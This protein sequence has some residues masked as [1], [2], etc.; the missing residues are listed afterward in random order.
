MSETLVWID[1]VIITCTLLISS[2]IGLYYRFSGGRQKTTEEFFVANRDMGVTTIAIGLMVSLLSAVSLLG[3]SSEIYMHGTHYVVI[4]L[5]YALATPVIAYFYLPVFFNLGDTSAFQYL[6][7][8]FGVKTR[9]VA[10][11]IFLVQF[12]L[13]SGVVLYAPAL[14]LEATTGLSTTISVIIIGAVCTFYSTIGGMKAVLITDV[15]QGILMIASVVI[16]IVTAVL[17]VGGINKIWDIAVEGKRIDFNSTSFDPTVRH[18]WWNLI[19][20][21]FFIYLSLYGVNQIQVQ[22]VLTIR[23]LKRAKA[24]VW[25]SLPITVI[26]VCGI[27]FSGLAL[28]SKYRNCDPRTAGA[29]ASNDQ[30]MPHYIMENLSKYPGIPGLFI[31]GIFS[32]GLSTVSAVQNSAAAIILE[33]YVKPVFQA[34]Q[35]TFTEDQSAYTSKFLAFLMGLVCLA[36]ALL[37]QQLG[38]LLQAALTIFGV[39]GGPLLGVYTLGMFIE[40]ADEISAI[41]GLIASFSL[42]LWIG[43]GEPKPEIPKLP[44]DVSGCNVTMT[45][46]TNNR[47]S[48]TDDDIFYLYRISYMW[49]CALGFVCCLLIGLLTSLIIN[50]LSERINNERKTLNPDLFTPLIAARIRKRQEMRRY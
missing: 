49:Y 35:K 9:L 11:T 36:V 20:G 41:L 44:V 39:V 32:A 26:L 28:Y 8:R 19:I 6:E 50:L 46:S 7:K 17:D 38:N 4:V 14:A 48:A 25:L 42:S 5:G 3:V 12:L 22:R 34:R 27:S 40:S 24:A 33:D 2:G 31:A 47:G 21:G 45:D 13:Y 23:N 1:Y 15:F 37:A 43:F 29:I 16:V 30:L 18:T 10:S